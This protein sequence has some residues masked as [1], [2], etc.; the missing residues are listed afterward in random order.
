M[1]RLSFTIRRSSIT[2]TFFSGVARSRSAIFRTA[3]HVRRIRMPRPLSC[4]RPNVFCTTE[5]YVAKESVGSRLSVDPFRT[6][7]QALSTMIFES[8]PKRGN[9]YVILKLPV[10]EENL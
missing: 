3:S 1:G 2:P 4:L 6:T 5:R 8:A 9:R 10:L 7:R